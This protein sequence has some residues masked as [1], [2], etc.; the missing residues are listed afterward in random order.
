MSDHD[1]VAEVG[2]LADAL[3]KYI[4]GQ[5]VTPE[6][7][8]LIQQA[9]AIADRPPLAGPTGYPPSINTESVTNPPPPTNGGGDTTPVYFKVL[10]GWHLEQ[11]MAD[12]RAHPQGNPNLYWEQLQAWNPG[13]DK[14]IHWTTD[15]GS[16][17]FINEATYRIK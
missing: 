13:V 3:G 8:S 1:L 14:N 2:P 6:Q 7:T 15:L 4:S 9:I 16:R 17:T 12:V 5:P 10:K 11:W